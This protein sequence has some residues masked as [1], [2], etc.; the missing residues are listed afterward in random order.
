MNTKTAQQIAIAFKRGLAF[1][2][3]ITRMAQDADPDEKWI[4]IGAEEGDD[5]KRHGGR[6]VCIS[7]STGKIIKGLSKDVAG[8][9]LNE[10]FKELKKTPE[11][12]GA[13]APAFSIKSLTDNIAAG[14][15]AHKTTDA[16]FDAKLKK[17]LKLKKADRDRPGRD[18]RIVKMRAETSSRWFDDMAKSLDY[19]RE[20]SVED[21][22][23]IK[24]YEKEITKH[25]NDLSDALKTA[26]RI[27]QDLTSGKA[28]AGV[29]KELADAMRKAENAFSDVAQLRQDLADTRDRHKKDIEDA[30]KEKRHNEFMEKMR[31]KREER[32]KAE[33][34]E[35]DRVSKLSPFDL[36]YERM[37]NK[38]LERRRPQDQ[39]AYK[40]EFA[41]KFGGN[42]AFKA[43]GDR[44]SKVL[45]KIGPSDP[46]YQKAK[47]K[48]MSLLPY[49]ADFY[50]KYGQPISNAQDIYSRSI[51]QDRVNAEKTLTNQVAELETYAK[52]PKGYQAKADESLKEA[53]QLSKDLELMRTALAKLP[54]DRGTN[55]YLTKMWNSISDLQDATRKGIS[56][57]YESTN[58]R[59]DS[60]MFNEVD[61]IKEDAKKLIASVGKNAK[62]KDVLAE[63]SR[64]Q[65]RQAVPEAT[66]EQL[67]RSVEYEQGRRDR[68]DRI[69][70]RA[71]KAR[72]EGSEHIRRGRQELAGIPL[73]QPN[74]EGR[75]DPILKRAERQYEAGRKAHEKAD[76][77]EQRA[78]GA[79]YALSNIRSDDPMLIQKLQ[80]KVESAATS[81]ERR[82]WRERLE[83]AQRTQQR[84]QSGE[85]L[86]ASNKLY[87]LDEDFTDGRVKFKF[88]GKPDAEVISVMKSNGFKWSPKNKAWQRQN[89]PNGLR[90]ARRAQKELE[91]FVTGDE[92]PEE[93]IRYSTRWVTIGRGARIMVDSNGTIRAGLGG[94]Y[95]GRQFADVFKSREITGEKDALEKPEEQIE[96][97]T[98]EQHAGEVNGAG[99]LD[100]LING[101][102]IWP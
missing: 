53:A 93:L 68:V 40:K 37:L 25:A 101:V 34:A 100:K 21:A 41:D 48:I 77:L 79:E 59:H 42:A 81:T 86:K 31:V 97:M 43:M 82:R 90:A 22:E 11:E 47:D 102:S 32:A 36:N 63:A 67:A 38:E 80:E 35:A 66:A 46:L 5:G 17:A 84:A 18:F 62:Y 71:E 69:A 15:A 58:W 94:K 91:R 2:R 52:D 72:E 14:I 10:A 54:N 26:A 9:T 74:I 95:N 60:Y 39:E 65:F 78:A 16:D 98:E 1:I 87:D 20:N 23:K 33:A 12:K 56:P 50:Q 28:D 92:M 44:V 49:S 55:T 19:I 99:V 24:G 57:L 7:K 8:M 29:V 73:G 85:G 89:T 64:G 30:E 88:D 13:K 4:T 75:L 83:Q 61:K 6:P 27:D 76:Y 96:E 45:S 51:D 70:A 3:G